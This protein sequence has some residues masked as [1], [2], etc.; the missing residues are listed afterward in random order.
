LTKSLIVLLAVGSAL[1]AAAQVPAPKLD[2]SPL[3]GTWEGAYQSDHGSGGL[4]LVVT[5]DSVW[6]ATLAS[7]PESTIPESSVEELKIDGTTISW[8]QSLM[9]ATCAASAELEGSALKGALSCNHG[10][11]EVRLTFLLTK[12]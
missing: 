8:T 3:L 11:N 7:A 4:R 2:G 12:Q 5:R 10:G 9:G 6:K 1:P